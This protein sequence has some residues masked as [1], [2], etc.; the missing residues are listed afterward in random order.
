VWLEPSAIITWI[1]VAESGIRDEKTFEVSFGKVTDFPS[2]VA[3]T[4]TRG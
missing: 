1:A 3:V 4:V 2:T